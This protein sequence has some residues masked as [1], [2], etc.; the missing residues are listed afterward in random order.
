M[1]SPVFSGRSSAPKL[2]RESSTASFRFALASSMDFPW[3]TTPSSTQHA[4]YQFSSLVITAFNR[5]AIQ[6]PSTAHGLHDSSDIFSQNA[7]IREASSGQPKHPL[8]LV[9]ITHT[10]DAAL[11]KAARSRRG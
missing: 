9:R 5:L 4:I 1:T 8:R 3:L 10:P 6:S 11:Q 2:S 7:S